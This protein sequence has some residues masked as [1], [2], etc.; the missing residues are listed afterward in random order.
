MCIFTV[1]MHCQTPF[2]LIY[3]PAKQ[4]SSCTIFMTVFDNIKPGREPT[5]YQMRGGPTNH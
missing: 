5:T 4:G 1:R 3:L 2:T